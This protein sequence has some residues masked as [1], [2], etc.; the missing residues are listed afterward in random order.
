M[1]THGPDT[2]FIVCSSFTSRVLCFCEYC[3]S[4]SF[5]SH[6]FSAATVAVA[7]EVE[8]S[9]FTPIMRPSY[10]LHGAHRRHRGLVIIAYMLSLLS[11]LFWMIQGLGTGNFTASDSDRK[12]Y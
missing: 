11:L 4:L 9:R 5:L 1:S 6:S 12:N 10:Q 2:S 3:S 8:L 7:D